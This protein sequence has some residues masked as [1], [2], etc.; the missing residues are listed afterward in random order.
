MSIQFGRKIGICGMAALAVLS[1]V[2]A[3]GGAEAPSWRLAYEKPGMTNYVTAADNPTAIR[4]EL[5][6]SGD[7]WSG[8][9]VNGE[10]GATVLALEVY[11]GDRPVDTEN[12]LL[13]VPWEEGVRIKVWPKPDMKF[14]KVGTPGHLVGKNAL[15]SEFDKEFAPT[16][17]FWVPAGDG[18]F[19]LDPRLNL[20]S[21]R[22]V[23]QW[24][25]LSDGKR[26]FY[27]ATHD[28]RN[29]AKTYLGI[30][31]SKRKT[32]RFGVRFNL[33][34][35]LGREFVVTPVVMAD[36]AGSWHMA[37]RRY[38]AWWNRCFKYAYVPERIKDMTGVFFVLLKQQNDEIVWPYTEFESLGKCAKSYGF[39]HVEFHAWGVGGHD[40]LYPEYEPDPA[41]GGR[42]GLIAGVKK[43]REMGIHA[44]VYSNGQL[45]ERETTKYWREKGNGGAIMMRDG[46]PHTEFWHKFRNAPG[47]TF[48]VVCPWQANWRDRM[49]EICRDARAYG[50]EGFFYDQ[51][52][53]QRPWQCFS[54]DHGHRV[55]EW[56]YTSDRHA[57][58]KEIA[59]V[60]HSED[61]EFVL[62]VEGY[63]D[64][65]FDSCAW[66]E[67][68]CTGRTEQR[69]DK[70]HV[71]DWFPEMTFYTFPEVV[72]TDRTITPCYDRRHMNSVVVIN[73]RVNFMVRYR[74]DRSFVE[75]GKVP[76]P[77]DVKQML[78]PTDWKYMAK[79]DWAGCRAYMKL[80]NDWRKANKDFLLRGTFK[81]DEGF[82]AR[83]DGNFV[84]NRWDSADG[85]TAILVW[86]AAETPQKIDVSYS[87]QLLYAEEPESG[88]VSA[89]TAIPANTL[90]LLVYRK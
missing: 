85:R 82:T 33:F 46:S 10:A 60:I 12:D 44:T 68:W 9:V 20:P 78:T 30:Y 84:A 45:Q 8:K 65:V 70:T 52:G 7:Q 74:I 25:T 6:R 58:F 26:G 48:D 3:N 88:K 47:H 13:Y 18:V 69:F 50:F 81:A 79:V 71:H 39:D 49:L 27:F 14:A 75:E 73:C 90:R 89:D 17:T 53:V 24:M 29:S 67:G 55:G 23:M 32:M 36:Y 80:V 76:G 4:V 66:Y 87:G 51:I 77:E 28:P 21:I 59:D 72:S 83:S 64:S 16:R 22:G 42:E 61:P 63:N 19:R 38:R 56:V 43:L 57:L 86:N 5:D 1:G 41:M 11:S 34:L 31:D 40:R 2:A 15:A 62:S 35:A 37:A 54:P